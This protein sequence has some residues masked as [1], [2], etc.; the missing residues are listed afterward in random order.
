MPLIITEP[1]KHALFQKLG[2]LFFG[3]LKHKSPTASSHS[4]LFGFIRTFEFNESKKQV[5]V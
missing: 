1:E 4:A 3:V 5:R 2:I